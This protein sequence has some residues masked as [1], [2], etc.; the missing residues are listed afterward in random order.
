MSLNDFEI[1]Q[2]IGNEEKSS[3][4]KVKRKKD[5]LF[6]SL[7]NI[8][9]QTL[10]KNEKENAINEIKLLSTLK[11]PN[12]IEFRK[13]FFDK[14]SNSLNLIFEF[15]NN[16][17]LLNKINYAIKNNMHMEECII[18]NVLTQMLHGLNYLHKKGII[19]RNLTSKN[20]FLTKLRLVKI[21]DFT[22]CCKLENNKKALTQVGTPFYTAP[23]IWN[24]EPYNYKCDIWSLGCIIYEMAS[25]SLPFNGNTIELLYENIMA[26]KMKPLPVFY[27]ENLKNI[28]NNMLTFDPSKRPSADILLNYPNIIKTTNDLNSIYDKYKIEQSINYQNKKI[29]QKRKISVNETNKNLDKNTEQNKN[30]EKEKY[31]NLSEKKE[32]NKINITNKEN[33]Q[34]KDNTINNK[35]NL[36]N[37]SIPDKKNSFKILVKDRTKKT[38]NINNATY[39]TLRE[40]RDLNNSKEINSRNNSRINTFENISD[41]KVVNNNINNI[42]QNITLSFKDLNNDQAKSINMDY[43]SFSISKKKK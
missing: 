31:Q 39:R 38:I 21:T 36:L 16:G 25:L 6:Y 11:H 20:I 8:K 7:K 40:R 17:N 42:K 37:T 35:D 23:E 10:E 27:S 33:N 12:I 43:N 22:V 4:F 13:A 24:E 34:P 18:W 1:I 3:I 14:P 26:K 29:Y 15:P 2:N 41:N 30:I 9:F 5:G 28:I 19:H 32:E